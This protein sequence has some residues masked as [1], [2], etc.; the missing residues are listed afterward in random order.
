M[1]VS[2]KAKPIY[3]KDGDNIVAAKIDKDKLEVKFDDYYEAMC[4]LLNATSLGIEEYD[5]QKVVV[6]DRDKY[7]KKVV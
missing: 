6:Y 5:E 1:S 4:K 3:T 2:L 7:S